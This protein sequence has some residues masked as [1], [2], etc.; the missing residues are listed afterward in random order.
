M[1]PCRLH[2]SLIYQR[3]LCRGFGGEAE[4]TER[5]LFKLHPQL[6]TTSTAVSETLSQIDLVTRLLALFPSTFTDP[7]LNTTEML[8]AFHSDNKL[9][10]PIAIE[11]LHQIPQSSAL[12]TLRLYHTLGVRYATLTHNCHNRFADAALIT[13]PKTDATIPAPP[14]HNGISKDGRAVIKEMN[15]L[16]MLV[17]LSHTSHKTQLDVLGAYADDWEGSVA[18]IMYSHSSAYSVC[19]HPRNVHDDVLAL[20]KKTNS[21]VMVNFAP[22]FISCTLPADA[23]PSDIEVEGGSTVPIDPLPDFY[24]ANSTLAHVVDHIVYMGEKIGYD[25]VGLGSDFDG[26]PSTPKGLED[27]SK[28]PD[29]VA[30]MLRRGVSDEDAGKVVGGNILRVWGDVEK[31]AAKMQ[32]EGTLPAED[33]VKRYFDLEEEYYA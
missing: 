2:L 28:W 11:G 10:S 29:L 33:D 8:S 9:I 17:D 5:F 23:K 16:G 4:I 12:S 19:P 32:K 13:D 30:E 15:R 1:D 31:V 27:V 24:P 20:V 25:H 21:V 18:P 26:I 6:T 22:D 7:T 3:I 14:F